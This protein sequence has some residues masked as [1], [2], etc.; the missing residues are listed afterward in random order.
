VFC[1]LNP[2]LRYVAP[3]KGELM[4]WFYHFGSAAHAYDATGHAV[5]LMPILNENSLSGAPPQVLEA[6]HLL[7]QSGAFGVQKQIQYDPYMRPGTAGRTVATSG[8]PR[9]PQSTEGLGPTA[10]PVSRPT[11][12]RAAA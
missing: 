4:E 9:G 3:Y 12:D 5:R 8:S 10:I 6:A 7:L 11:A 2:F 1:Q